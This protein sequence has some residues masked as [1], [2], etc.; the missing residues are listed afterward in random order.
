MTNYVA[1]SAGE[2]TCFSHQ[3]SFFELEEPA[4]L[5]SGYSRSPNLG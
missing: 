4:P 3:P 5:R 1:L 2:N